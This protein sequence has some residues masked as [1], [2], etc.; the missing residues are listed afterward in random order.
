MP[1]F[2]FPII[3]QWKFEVAIATKVLQQ[4]QLKKKNILIEVNN[5]MN[6]SAM[7]LIAW[8]DFF[9]YFLKFNLSVAMATKLW[10]KNVH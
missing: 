4:Q 7:S 9:L 3:R 2:I 1:I 10:R 6:N 5:Y 8:V